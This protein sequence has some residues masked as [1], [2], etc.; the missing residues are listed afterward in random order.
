MSL[1]DR[2]EI[3]DY[4]RKLRTLSNLADNLKK[5]IEE[6]K[7]LLANLK[8]SEAVDEKI[9]R[10]MVEFESWQGKEAELRKILGLLK[11]LKGTLFRKSSLTKEDLQTMYRDIY[12]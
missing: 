7:I 9:R 3:D 11:D 4:Q 2:L 5:E 8:D 10:L 6:S 12:R 1:I